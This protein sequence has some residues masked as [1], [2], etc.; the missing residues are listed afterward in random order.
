VH[1]PCCS[2]LVRLQRGDSA[3]EQRLELA[4]MHRWFNIAWDSA[5]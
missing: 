3:A 4:R 2:M 5:Q 1:C